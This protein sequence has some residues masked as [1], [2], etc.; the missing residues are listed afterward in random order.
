MSSLELVRKTY[1]YISNIQIK[2][3]NL[4]IDIYDCLNDT[5]NT[6]KLI[7]TNGKVF[8]EHRYYEQ[9]KK[10]FDGFKNYCINT[11]Y[12]DELLVM[13]S[14]VYILCQKILFGEIIK[15]G[16]KIG[17]KYKE[18]FFAKNFKLLRQ[19]LKKEIFEELIEYSNYELSLI[20]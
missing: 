20:K 17:I 19:L 12:F 1:F 3:R 9:L 15:K 8:D 7:L 18:L 2:N 4:C 14:K 5:I 11:L 10:G 16:N 6:C 13:A